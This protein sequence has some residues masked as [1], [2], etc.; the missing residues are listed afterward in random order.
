MGFMPDQ[1]EEVT[2]AKRML[3]LSLERGALRYGNFTLSS[4]L[5]T[6]YYM[7]GRLL[8]LDPEGACLVGRALM[9]ILQPL[10]ISRVGGPTVS[11][12]P[13]VTA[14][15]M[16]SYMAGEPITSFIVRKEVKGHGT[17]RLIEGDMPEGEKV[18]IVDDVC[19]TG[20]SIF[21]AIEAVEEA[22][23]EVVKVVVL[24]DRC[25]GGS[26]E[27]RRRGYD[28]VCLMQAT[29]EGVVEVNPEFAD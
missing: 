26:D 1:G 15:S 3:E 24:V 16:T 2:D 29:P 5:R 22:G 19:T 13:I 11:A 25:Q 17:E 14:I 28:L 6:S 7:D 4:G 10:G 9:D 18:A 12:V 23:C 8:T 20:S 27:L 21:H